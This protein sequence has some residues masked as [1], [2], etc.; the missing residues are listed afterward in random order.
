MHHLDVG[1]VELG[2]GCRHPVQP[3][4]LRIDQDEG[5]RSIGNGQGKAGQP[6]ARSKVGPVLRWLRSSNGCQAE[7]VI[8]VPLPEPLLFPW[9]KEPEPDR[10]GVCP[11]KNILVPR[12]QDRARL[13]RVAARRMFH[14]KRYVGR[15]TTRR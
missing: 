5:R 11:F 9:A 13:R 6:R 7:G 8:Q 12:G 2:S 10:I 1:E 3:A 15:M 14:V 4:A